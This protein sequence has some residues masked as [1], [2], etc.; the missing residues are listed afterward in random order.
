MKP[1]VFL[2]PDRIRNRELQEQL[3]ALLPAWFGQPA[4]NAKYAQQAE[5]LDG[6]VAEIDGVRRGLLL[7]K[8][9]GAMGAEIFWLGVDPTCH[10]SG[11]GRALVEAATNDAR[12]R[13]VKYLFVATLHP[14]DPYEPYLRTRKFYESMGFAYV[15]E[16]Q[17]RSYS[18]S[19]IAYY[20]KPL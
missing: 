8:S 6:Y 4:S 20:L 11:M 2:E 7:L 13:G 1:I 19:P 10:R 14:I 9:T 18:Q 5:V 15:L 16:E 17:F 12:K 3:T